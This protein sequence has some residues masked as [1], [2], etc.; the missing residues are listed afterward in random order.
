MLDTCKKKDGEGERK[1]SR[2]M[3][4]ED[5]QKFY[6]HFK[7]TCPSVD[8]SCANADQ[9]QAILDRGSHLLF[10]AL[11]SSAFVIWMRCGT[12]H[13]IIESNNNLNLCRIGEVTNLQYKNF[14]FGEQQPGSSSSRERPPFFKLNL[15]NRKNW[16]K[17]EKN[18]EHQLSGEEHNK[19]SDA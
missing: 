4:F 8:S 1:H 2:A 13:M 3:S 15:R 9:T 14:E 11:S 7:T 17:R 12:T 16:Q 19:S 6:L 10:N 18:G 5:M